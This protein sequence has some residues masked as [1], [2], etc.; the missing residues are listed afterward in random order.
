VSKGPDAPPVEAWLRRHYDGGLVLMD[1]YRRPIGPVESG[2]PMHDFIGVGNKPYWQESRDNPGRWAT[3]VILQQGDTDAVWKGFG[4]QARS[5]L[6]DHFAEVYRSGAIFVYKRRPPASGFVQKQGQHLYLGATR[7][8]A[9]GVNSYD[10][11]TQPQ[12]TIDAQI[13]ALSNAGH[14]TV[15]TWCFDKDGGISDATL[16][17][18]ADT[19]RF[20]Y[21]RDVR[22]VCTLANYYSDFGGQP[23]FTPPGE[24]FFVSAAARLRYEAQVRRVLQYV[25]GDGT[26]LAD[27]PGVLA[28]DLINEPRVNA[29]QPTD[30]VRNWTDQMSAFVSSID[31]RHLV[32]VGA[33]GFRPGYPTVAT[34][35][36]P[37]GSGFADVCTLTSIT[38]CSVHLFPKY[39]NNPP[40]PASPASLL[41][42]WRSDADRLGKPVLVEELGYSLADGGDTAARAAFFTATGRAVRSSDLDGALLWNLGK[43]ADRSFTLAW[44]D[45]TARTA[46]NRW[47]DLI[48]PTLNR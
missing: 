16:A 43:E 47:P 19:V 46:L 27:S 44:N 42:S 7:W 4:P 25:G 15:R 6:D 13:D 39:L 5:I 20:A 36:G 1:D 21:Q 33:E 37:A 14:N 18:L 28:W 24:D 26:R 35:A 22:L 45:P 8:R 9:A 2:V 40:A 34:M 31:Q 41:Q 48:R 30:S 38:L 12:A 17:R 3:W 11:L 29:G 10:L 23:H 32:T